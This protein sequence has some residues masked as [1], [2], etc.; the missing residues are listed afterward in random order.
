VRLLEPEKYGRAFGLGA[1]AEFVAP[2]AGVS[3]VILAYDAVFMEID[4]SLGLGIGGDPVNAKDAANTYSFDL[5]VAF[6]VHRGVKADFSLMAGG[7][8]TLVDPPGGP[9]HALGLVL[10]GGVIRIFQ[11]PNVALT[12]TLGVAGVLRGD[13]SLFI[14]GAKPLGSASLVYYF[15]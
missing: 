7:G 14:L 2:S 8:T 15:R 1:Q 10:G 13:Q 12:G 11:S 4:A 3:S 5:R 9:W 6:P